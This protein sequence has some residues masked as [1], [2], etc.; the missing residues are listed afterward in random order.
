MKKIVVAL[1]SLTAVLLFFLPSMTHA[2][3]NTPVQ[4]YLNGEKLEPAVLPYESKGT[5]MVPLRV[6]TES[7]GAYL[8]WD[9]SDRD[10]VTVIKDGLT[11]VL[12]ANSTIGYVNGEEVRFP[13]APV[14]KSG[15]T[16]LPIRF[17]AEKFSFKVAWKSTENAVL[18]NSIVQ[19]IME[20]GGSEVE[21][22]ELTEPIDPSELM[23]LGMMDDQFIIEAA[24]PIKPSVFTLKNPDR[25]VI[26]LPNLYFGTFIPEP[27]PAIMGTI[28]SSN[29]FVT[30]IR[31]AM[32]SPEK[33]TIRVVLETEG[34]A[35][36]EVKRNLRDSQVLISLRKSS[37]K[38]NIVV[39]DAG[40][41]D[42]D[43]GAKSVTGKFE[44][45]FN[46]SIAKKV[47][48]L[49]KK[50]PLIEVH[51]TRS[52]DTFV[53]LD[54][55]AAFANKLNANVFV[56]IHGNSFTSKSNGTQTY[57]YN[58]YSKGLAGII[59]KHLVEATGFRDD[60]VRKEDFRVIKKTEMPGVL[61]EVGYL[62]NRAEEALMYKPAF[63]DKV[64]AA[65]VA[66]IK[67][68]LKL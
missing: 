21:L 3:A 39:I 23:F 53:T 7:L 24:G 4:L 48:A 33:S 52:N 14:I 37:L 42:R 28:V 9:K 19:P 11:V 64:A 16:M 35:A 5:T 32:N 59:H 25:V 1:L 41:G 27:D 51:M 45:T 26:D 49:L 2:A 20:P 67:E 31:Y 68:H 8:K 36:F 65:I 34:P 57:Y 18:M 40:H 62:S 43:P 12:R 46:L 54:N 6:I 50:E 10:K 61:L 13:A 63:Q 60:K 15:I 44:K 56:S 58:S 30:D 47:E 29:P 17:L 55:R 66:G 38:K 22:A